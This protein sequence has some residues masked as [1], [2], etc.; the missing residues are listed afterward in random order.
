MVAA[1]SFLADLHTA[2]IIEFSAS[3][4]R[5]TEGTPEVLVIVQRI[6][7]LETEVSVELAT[8]N[9]TATAGLDYVQVVTNVVFQPGDTNRSVAISL[10]NDG[11]VEN[12]E[13]FKVNLAQPTGNAELGTLATATIRLLDND[14]GLA[15]EFP[16]YWVR[17]D[18][19]SVVVGVLRRDDGSEPVTVELATV[20]GTALAGSDFV[21]MTNTVLFAPRERLQLVTIPILN[22]EQREANESFGLLLT[23]ATGGAVLGSPR[24]AGV[25]IFGNDPGVQFERGQVFVFEDQPV[26]QLTVVRGNDRLLQAFTVDFETAD[27]TALAGTDYV[28][29]GGTLAFGDGEMTRKLTV[30]L[31]DDGVAKNDRRFKVLLRNPTGE[32]IL[33]SSAMITVTVCDAG[34]MLPHRFDSAQVTPDRE[35]RLTLGGGY[36]AG[37]GL[38]RRYQPY[39]DLFPI[40]TSANLQDWMPLKWA[41]RT[42]ASTAALVYVDAAGA[43]QPQRFYRTPERPWIAPCLPPTGPYAV[44]K[45]MRLITEPSRRNRFQVSTNGTFMFCVWYPA[46]PGPGASPAPFEDEPL[47]SDLGYLGGAQWLDRVPYFVSYSFAD[48]P[49]L[50]TAVPYPVVLFSHGYGGDNHY[51]CLEMAEHLASHG[52]A[53]VSMNHYDAWGFVWPDG[54]LFKRDGDLGVDDVGAAERVRDFALVLEALGELNRSDAILAGGLDLNRLAAAGFSGGGP[55][56]GEFC[57][58]DARC[59]A[60]I[61]LDGGADANT[62]ELVRLGLQKP[63]LMFN[64]TDNTS[65]TLFRLATGDAYW[66]QVNGLTHNDFCSWYWWHSPGSQ[67]VRE[68]WKGMHACILSLLNRYVKGQNDGLLDDNPSKTYPQLINF[69]RK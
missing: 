18:E 69:K 60:A 1:L 58:I 25:K 29:T 10:L 3:E 2:S 28:K 50:K 65:D 35:V 17:E 15:F 64:R 4:Y 43:M 32:M 7:D 24:T 54:R 63:S 9:F 61:S 21:G 41:V 16:D 59:L 44:G 34:E 66:I 11:I 40:E 67:S 6:G 56:A 45:T 27:L 20:N 8:T 49:L 37:P 5:V 46:V 48:A 22:D 68:A 39:F 38:S 47:A 55:T 31:L 19:E 53:V 42:N 52:Y 57:R 30:P 14:R 26:V 51:S 33:G 12:L 62:P 23:N 36:T 13:V